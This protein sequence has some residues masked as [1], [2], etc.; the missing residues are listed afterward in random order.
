MA[1]LCVGGSVY[2]VHEGAHVSVSLDPT[3][4]I[5]VRFDIEPPQAEVE[6]IDFLASLDELTY[7]A[8]TYVPE[9]DEKDILSM[10][11]AI[12]FLRRT[13]DEKV[14]LVMDTLRSGS[15]HGIILHVT[16]ED[17]DAVMEEL[18]E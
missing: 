9:F 5:V 13:T 1:K 18:N 7:P 12:A 8:Q 4:E 15:P 10:V 16:P 6:V 17:L 2:H 3:G 11:I 14:R